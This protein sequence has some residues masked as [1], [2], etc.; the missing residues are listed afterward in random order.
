MCLYVCM[1][2][3]GFKYIEQTL[4]VYFSKKQ[5]EPYEK[6]VN[7]VMHARHKYSVLLHDV[8]DIECKY[9]FLEYKYR[10]ILHRSTAD[11][12]AA[13]AH[14][15]TTVKHGRINGGKLIIS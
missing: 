15:Q 11:C 6:H 9:G 8:R 14:G 13:S 5:Q 7:V 10:T 12:T 2:N 1:Q 4:T 3:R